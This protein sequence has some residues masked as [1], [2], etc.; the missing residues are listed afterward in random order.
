MDKNNNKPQNPFRVTTPEDLS[1]KE[2]RELFVEEFAEFNQLS[3]EG[4][5]LLKGARGMGK[6]MLFRYMNIDCQSTPENGKEFKDLKYLAFYFPVKNETFIRITELKRFGDSYEAMLFNE[7]IMVLSFVFRVFTKL[8]EMF[9]DITNLKAESFYDYY[10]NTFLPK[11]QNSHEHA[12]PEK[13][14]IGI[15]NAI[16]AQL[17]NEYQ[18]AMNYVNKLGF[19]KETLP[20]FQSWFF[21]YLDFL[22][23]LLS[24][25][26]KIDFFP[27]CPVYLM[28]DDAHS[29]T[30]LQ[31]QILNSWIAT[32]TSRKV[33]IKVSTQYNYK[34]FYTVTGA[35]IDTPH[36]YK[37]IDMSDIYTARA[38]KGSYKDMVRD[39]LKKRFNKYGHGDID[40]YKFFPVNEEQEKKIDDIYN[41]YVERHKKNEGRGYYLTDDA[42][43][44]ARADYI[45]SSLPISYNASYARADYIMSLQGTSKSGSTYS[46]SGF[47]QLVNISS[48]IIRYFLDAA[49][50]MYAEQENKDVPILHIEP[51]IQNAIVRELADKFL[52]NEISDY[53]IEGHNNAVPKEDFSK[54]VNLINAFGLLFS[55]IMHSNRSERR[56][57]SIAISDDELSE[58]THRI[59]QLGVNYAYLH[60]S[61]IGRKERGRGRTWLYVLNRRLAP[62]WTLDPN[63]FAG[64][65]FIQ[66]K[67]LEA[68]MYNPR[69][70]LNRLKDKEDYNEENEPIQLTLFD[71]DTR[72]VVSQ[73]DNIDTNILEKSEVINNEIHV[74]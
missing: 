22:L 56:V 15:M 32:R 58:E 47:D 57:F 48:G 65:L 53:Q 62:I 50:E 26:Q 64:Y 30:F 69:S 74:E 42:Y 3:D 21:N 6:S 67:Y 43:R 4:H 63:S 70:I 31:T 52:K 44:Y 16:T 1:V 10:I 35:T 19:C 59:L 72:E 33:S 73:I 28:I 7:H 20:E 29:M 46:Y 66:N 60:R 25:L 23:P 61:T 14:I 11:F 17:E 41:A 8:K 13:T 40:P 38:R 36:D 5:M 71:I 39:I 51:G 37:Q 9:R 68:A 45:I 54:L 55:T 2:M 24:N 27:K 18:K 12:L 49:F 34:T